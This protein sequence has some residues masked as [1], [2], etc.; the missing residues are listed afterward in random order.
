[1]LP[2]LVLLAWVSLAGGGCVTM[3]ARR[4]AVVP[5]PSAAFTAMYGARPDERFPLPATEIGSIDYRY[6]RQE[7]A[8]P[9]KSGPP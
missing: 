6:F 7:V 9:L 2:I 4:E 3:E 5:P 1:M 8:C